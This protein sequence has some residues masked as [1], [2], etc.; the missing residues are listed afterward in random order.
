MLGLSLLV[1]GYV[2]V[3]TFESIWQ[4]KPKNLSLKKHL[5]NVGHAALV[6]LERCLLVVS[7][8]DCLQLPSIL[9]IELKGEFNPSPST[10]VVSRSGSSPLIVCVFPKKLGQL[11]RTRTVWMRF[12]RTRT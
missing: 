9:S 6:L 11:R 3:K 12:V 4:S 8:S 2:L 1:D 10:V 7:P 5:T